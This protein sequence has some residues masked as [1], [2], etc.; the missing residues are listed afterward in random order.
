MGEID[1]LGKKLMAT[2]AGALY[3]DEGPSVRFEFGPG[4]GTATID[5]TVAGTVAVEI[6]SR[7]PKQIRGALVDL[8]MHPYPKKL[9]L[10][11]PIHSGNPKTAVNQAEV[12]LRRFVGSDNCRVVCVTDD[13][14]GSVGSIRAALAELGVHLTH[15]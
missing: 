4:A 1:R 8:I 7:V 10:L 2:A 6:E 3:A 11:I 15:G 13:I 12:I 5:G 9:L 14:E